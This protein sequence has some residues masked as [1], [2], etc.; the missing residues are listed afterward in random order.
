MNLNLSGV[1]KFKALNYPNGTLHQSYNININKGIRKIPSANKRTTSI[2]FNKKQNGN[3]KNVNGK[4]LAKFSGPLSTTIT[5]NL[6]KENIGRAK[7]NGNTLYSY[8]YKNKADANQA[9]ANKAAAN[10]A[11]NQAAN[12]AASEY[13]SGGK[14]NTKKI[15]KKG[16][17]KTTKK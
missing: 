3:H 12:Q 6:F 14:K 15:S 17:K 13:V 16:T 1:T 10:K 2:I 4:L 7:I 5:N 9:A 11:A 8:T